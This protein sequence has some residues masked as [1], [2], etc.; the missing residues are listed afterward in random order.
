MFKNVKLKLRK[1]TSNRQFDPSTDEQ[2]E[3]VI[4]I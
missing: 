2:N 1:Y 3:A 4:M